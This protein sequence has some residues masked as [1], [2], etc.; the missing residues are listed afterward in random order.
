[1][2]FP[3]FIDI[4]DR[5]CVVVGGGN[6]AS[7]RINA[8]CLFGARIRVI[9]PTCTE[10][11][12]QLAQAKRVSLIRRCYQTRDLQG[13]FMV[14]IATDQRAVNALVIMDAAAR[15][16]PVNV[17][18]DPDACTFLFPSLVIQ[19]HAVIGISTSGASP[20]MSKHLRT[21]LIKE[22]E[23]ATMDGSMPIKAE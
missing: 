15:S 7:R 3:V 12:E 23:R 17:A 22:L 19:N 11:I 9:S 16:I 21:V 6:V 10:A 1:M 18:D 20:S 2:F 13:A 5:L 14:V 8:L 4:Q